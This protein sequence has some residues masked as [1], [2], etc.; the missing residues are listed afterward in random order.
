MGIVPDTRRVV[1]EVNGILG[2]TQTQI[3]SHVILHVIILMGESWAKPKGL[4]AVARSAP[5]EHPSVSA[6]TEVLCYVPYCNIEDSIPYIT[7]CNIEDSFTPN[8]A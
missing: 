3:L 4:L 1:N 6:Q 7:F 2:G 8:G 5:G